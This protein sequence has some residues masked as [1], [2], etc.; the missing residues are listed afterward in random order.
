MAAITI[1][2]IPGD[3]PPLQWPVL[4]PIILCGQRSLAIFCL[5]I[6]LSLA[7]HFV[8]VEI[9]NLIPMQFMISGTGIAL[10]IA[11]AWF[12]TWY[13]TT[14]KRGPGPGDFAVQERVLH[15]QD[16]ERDETYPS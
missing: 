5:G 15:L 9:T 12:M 8:M 16:A 1:R 13:E 4:R 6:F 11:A 10:M 7:G 2:F 14:E 3:R